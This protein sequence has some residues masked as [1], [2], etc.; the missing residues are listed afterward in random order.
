MERVWLSRMRWRMRGAWLWPVFAVLT[1]AEAVVLNELPVSGDGPGGFVAG[2]LLAGFG[3]L[4]IVAVIAPLVALRVRRRSPDMPRPVAVDRAGTALLGVAA[5][6]LVAAGLVHRPQVREEERARL[7]QALA[8]SGYVHAQAPEFRP[9]LARADSLRLSDD[10][11]RTCVPGDDPK[12]PLCLIV[13]T[14]QSPPGVTVDPD[15][16]ANSEYTRHGGFD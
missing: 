16:A 2:L 8:V 12:R 7:A 5:A 4:A 3:N 13:T 14:D 11:Y 1:L 6:V 10:L 15:R 9:G